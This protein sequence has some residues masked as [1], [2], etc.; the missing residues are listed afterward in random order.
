MTST[1]SQRD[2]GILREL[3]HVVAE[4]AALPDQARTA[5]RWRCQN[6]LQSVRPM[7]RVYQLPWRELDVDGELATKTEDGWARDVEQG[8][9]QTLYQWKHMRW[10][11]VV[12]PV[13]HTPYVVHSTGYGI[14]AHMDEIPHDEAGGVT[15]KRYTC[16]IFDQSD[17]EKIRF[18]EL[19]LDKEATEALY[20]RAADLFEGILDVEIQGC[21]AHSYAPWDRLAEWC[22]PQQV[23]MDL[24]LRPDFIHAA[25]ERLTSAYMHELDQ[26]EALNALSFGSGNYGVGEGGLGYTD[27]LPKPRAPSE[28]VRLTQQWGGAMA[29]IFSEVSPEMHEEFALAYEKRLLDRFG[30]NYY[31]CCE[32]LDRKVDVI[33]RS[34]PALRKISMSP[35]VDHKRGADAIAG[36]F[37]YSAKPNPAFLANDVNWDKD[38]ARSELEAILAATEGR[39]VELILKDVSTVRFDP[40]R[41]WDW[42]EMAMTMARQYEE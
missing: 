31:G 3:G 32:P 2:R 40:G 33:S 38:S 12:E 7:V 4:I 13:F 5:E 42:T 36:R 18:P 24:V 15:A 8:L 27:D 39:N 9:R 19:T 21:V 41:V 35:W 25:M 23:L 34:L 1:L 22:N 16:Q 30:L 17:L 26:L 20:Q 6:D 37:V 11:M 14:D 29:Q 10:D 28:P